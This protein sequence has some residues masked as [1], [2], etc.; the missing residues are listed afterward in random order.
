LTGDV[1]SGVGVQLA[2][3]L[4]ARDLR[5]SRQLDLLERYR[6]PLLSLTVV[7]PGPVKHSESVERVFAAAAS[8]VS[9]IAAEAGWAVKARIET[10]AQTG[11]ELLLAVDAPPLE[12][13]AALVA[14]EDSHRWGRLFDLD[15]VTAAG[16]L[17]RAEIGSPPRCCL[18][19]A[20]PA[21]ACTRSQT[22]NAAEL[23]QAIAAIMER[24]AAPGRK[25][26]GCTPELLGALAAEALRFEVR[27][28]PKPGLV[29][30]WNS[31]AHDDCELGTF[32]ASA[33]ALQPWFGE[34]AR[35]ATAADWTPAVAQA[36]GQEAE[37]AMF[38][39]TGGVNTHKGAIYLLGWLCVAAAQVLAAPAGTPTDVLDQLARL[40][41]PALTAWIA[42][43]GAGTA[44]TNG[45]RAYQSFRVT[46]VRGE[47][48]SGLA[49]VRQFALPAWRRATQLGWAEDDAGLAALVA[50][51]RG[52][53][54]TT[55]IARGGQIALQQVRRW[56]VDC[57][58]DDPGLLRRDLR[59]ADGEFSTLRWSP[60]GSA[61]L[62]AATWFLIQL[63]DHCAGSAVSSLQDRR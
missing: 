43:L 16:P 17:S 8:Q 20:Q 18:V 11:P 4:A 12:C 52:C 19:C 60:G 55:L 39:A 36:L 58:L 47:A 5:R 31:G 41:S 23:A 28:A 32:L 13:K 10:H 42:G 45:E 46:G 7:S 57:P 48:A 27:L 2:E 53:A 38:A 9:L 6:S 22:H 40:T 51:M 44:G 35:T 25:R 1:V 14:L 26:T 30:V 63:G 37:A 62:L 54:D 61:D 29:D 33:D 24:T 15:V 59:R 3:M 21:A 56:A 49:N 34:L 50:L